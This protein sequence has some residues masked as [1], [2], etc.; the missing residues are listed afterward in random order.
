VNAGTR[1]ISTEPQGRPVLNVDSATSTPAE[2]R[3]ADAAVSFVGSPDWG[4][5]TGTRSLGDGVLHT[6]PL[7]SEFAAEQRPCRAE[8]SSA[9][10]AEVPGRFRTLDASR[11]TLTPRTND[12]VMVMLTKAPGP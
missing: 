5:A 12:Q 2:N 6:E 1:C 3:P 8:S 4:R 9:A 10:V 11:A 7:S